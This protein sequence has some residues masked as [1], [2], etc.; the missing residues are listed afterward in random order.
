MRLIQVLS[1]FTVLVWLIMCAFGV[2]L[3]AYSFNDWPLWLAIIFY[4]P[5]IPYVAY[6]KHV[7][8]FTMGWM[9]DD[10]S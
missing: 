9:L 1:F 10:E 2:P 5:F 8:N 6:I 7:N 4:V 3:L